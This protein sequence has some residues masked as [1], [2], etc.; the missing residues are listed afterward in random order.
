MSEQTKQRIA[1]KA[2]E[3]FRLPS[4]GMVVYIVDLDRTCSNFD[5]LLHKDVEIDGAIRFVQAVERFTHVPPW[6]KGERI[7]LAVED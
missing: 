2:L 5:H 3:F 7:G 1:F 4:R 6:E